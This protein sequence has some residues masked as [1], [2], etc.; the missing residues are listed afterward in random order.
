M[1][2]FSIL[3]SIFQI[4][5]E[6]E[7]HLVEKCKQG[8]ARAKEW[9]YKKHSPWMLG[10]S[11]RYFNDRMIAEDIVH[12][13]F[14]SIY[15]NIGN[16]K[17]NG[18]LE[19]WMKRIVV[20]NCLLALK[21]Q[22]DAFS[23]DEINETEIENESASEPQNLKDRILQTD[24]PTDVVLSIIN[25]LPTG[26]KTVFNLYVFEKYN[27]SQIAEE[28]GISEGTSKSQLLRARRLIQ[29]R[30]GEW[31]NE[32][33]KKEE[34]KKVIMYSIFLCMNDDL[35]YIDKIVFEKLNY[36]CIPMVSQP[37]V[38]ASPNQAGVQSGIIHTIK[39]LSFTI[40]GKIA[41]SAISL[42]VGTLSLYFFFSLGQDKP[43]P[44]SPSQKQI[45][46]IIKIDTVTPTDTPNNSGILLD[47][48][49]K[50]KKRFE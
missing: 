8:D 37:P 35:D 24:I 15:E 4:M 46:E 27:H 38:F 7:L 17:Q 29:Q 21:S 31:M 43:V 32:S 22:K 45:P 23:I 1:Q 26:F 6:K 36:Y 18:A 50:T 44:T 12:D 34:K 10:I 20:N 13:S 14:I 39:K 16:L 42:L 5:E 28:L 33:E 47:T 9:L 49:A 30:M 25:G 48:L 2:P 41:L 19:G 40:S 3:S 11:M